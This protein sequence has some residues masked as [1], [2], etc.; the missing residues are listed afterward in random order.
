MPLPGALPASVAALTGRYSAHLAGGSLNG[1][2]LVLDAAA[3]A[4]GG[5]AP[6]YIDGNFQQQS[7]YNHSFNHPRDVCANNSSALYEEY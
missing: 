7:V 6:V 3:S 5:E 2:I 4:V 1:M